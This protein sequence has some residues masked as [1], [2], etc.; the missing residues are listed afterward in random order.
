[1]KGSFTR[2]RFTQALLALAA[3]AAVPLG[4]LARSDEAFKARSSDAALELLFGDRPLQ[5]SDAF[6]FKV[7]NIAE[8][9]SIVPVTVSADGMEGVKSISLFVDA[10]P[11]PLSARFHFMP[12]AVPEFKTRIKMGESSDVRAI[13]ETEGGLYVATKNVKVTL[14]GCGG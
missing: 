9:G 13:V 14:G 12:G 6:T 2:R 11:N 4:A 1:M 3:F 8:D 7:P 5:E 10:N